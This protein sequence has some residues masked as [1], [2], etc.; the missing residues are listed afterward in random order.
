M[1]KDYE[2]DRYLNTLLNIKEDPKHEDDF[3]RT[4]FELFVRKWLLRSDYDEHFFYLKSIYYIIYIIIFL[5]LI[6]VSII[7]PDNNMLLW[8]LWGFIG[9]F[10]IPL[11]FHFLFLIYMCDNFI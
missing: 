10:I 9:Y 2:V 7:S 8:L 1:K 5:L 4:P 11:V 6:T 3:L